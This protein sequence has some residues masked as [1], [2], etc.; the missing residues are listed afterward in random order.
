MSD[1]YSNMRVEEMCSK[2]QCC[3]STLYKYFNKWNIT[4]RIKPKNKIAW[5]CK[6]SYD[7]TYFYGINDE[8]KAY[9]LGLLLADGFVNNQEL[10]IC[11][12]KDDLYIIESFR[13]DIKSNHPIRVNKDGNPFLTIA[14]RR[15]CSSL[16][17]KGFNHR[18]SYYI[19]FD[20]VINSVPVMLR[21]HFIR[22]MFD[23]DGCIRWYKY[24]YLKKPQFHF[25]YTGL[26]NVCNY[27]KPLFN[28]NRKLVFEGNK[29][30]TLVTRDPAKIIEIYN[31][32][33]KDSTI[34]MKRKR[35]IFEEIKMMTFNDYNK[36]ISNEMKV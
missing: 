30:Y 21:S 33:Y 4:R 23:G 3:K 6:Y 13:D 36:A 22:G 24:D 2:Y 35:K 8:H 15:L 18:K 1:Y 5:N 26:E 7:Y 11:L 14:S 28:I 25:G 16:L 31:F 27:L 29:T 34:F 19:D 9:W 17:E 10:S 20:K 32:L 12:K